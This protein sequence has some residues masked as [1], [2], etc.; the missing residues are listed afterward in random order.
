VVKDIIVYGSGGAAKGYMEIINDINEDCNEWNL[1]GFL[2]DDRTKHSLS[3]DGV[4][5]LGD[6]SILK[7]YSSIYIIIA[8]GSPSL[9]RAAYERVM[10]VQNN[11]RFA[12]LVHPRSWVARGV[13]LGYGTTVYPMAAI[14]REAVVGN[15]GLVN[16]NSTTGHDARVG[17]FVTIAPGA[18]ILGHGRVETGVEL[19]S[20]SVVLPGVTIGAWSVLG[21]GA[22]ATRD[23]APHCTAVGIPA[24]AVNPRQTHVDGSVI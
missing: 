18:R 9:R 12:T 13:A 15:F 7:K 5:I 16:M 6:L 22:V 24:L 2:D 17:D 21:A 23:V 10:S 3:L 8:L 1:L 14:N 4:A 20:N 19:G 11:A